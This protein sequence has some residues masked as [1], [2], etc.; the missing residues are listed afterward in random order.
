MVRRNVGGPSLV[1]VEGSQDN[2]G[3]G[4]EGAIAEEGHRRQPGLLGG[5]LDAADVIERRLEL[6]AVRREILTQS[7]SAKAFRGE[8]VRTEAKL[9]LA[10]GRDY[11]PVS[12]LLLRIREMHGAHSHSSSRHRRQGSRCPKQ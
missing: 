9:A 3:K 10:E 8:L 1:E 5:A 12:V 11:E 2:Y 6:G 7:I 4:Q